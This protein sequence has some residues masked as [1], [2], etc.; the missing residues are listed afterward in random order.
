MASDSWAT[1]RKRVKFKGCYANGP[2]F[3]RLEPSNRRARVDP[4]TLRLDKALTR[5]F[6]LARKNK[7]RYFALQN[8]AQ[9]CLGAK[10]LSKKRRPNTDCKSDD[11]HG[12]KGG[13]PNTNSVFELLDADLTDASKFEYE[14]PLVGDMLECAPAEDGLFPLSLTQLFHQQYFTPSNPTKGQLIYQS[15]GSGKTCLGLNVIGNFMGKWRIFWVTRWSLRATPLKN[16]YQDICQMKLREII[17]SDQPLT[18]KSTGEVLGRTR[19]EKIAFIRSARGPAAL[20]SY[21]IQI[22]KQRILTYDDLIKM[23]L[24]KGAM[25]KKLREQQL[26]TNDLGDIGYK[27]LFVF[28]EAHNLFTSDLPSDERKE[29][30]RKISS[31]QFPGKT[32]RT[33]AEVYGQIPGLPDRL[34]GRDAL[35][36][37]LYESYRRSG[38]Q[39][40]KVLFLTATPMSDSPVQLFKMLN[41]LLPNPRQRLSL[42]LSDYYDPASL[43]LK[44]EQVVKFAKACYGRVSYLNITQD[45]TK[46]AKKV[47]GGVTKNQLEPFYERLVDKAVAKHKNNPVKAVETYRNM[48]LAARV[49]GPFF[50]AEVIRQHEQSYVDLMDSL[51]TKTEVWHE[52]YHSRVDEAKRVF[53]QT[54]K[55]SDEKAYQVRLDAY[56][57]WAQKASAKVPARVQEVLADDGRLLS[58]AEWFAVT[59]LP[60]RH[61]KSKK[62]YTKA[63]KLLLNFLIQDA[64]TGRYR[65]R[66]W[67]EYL[68]LKMEQGQEI[69]RLDRQ[70]ETRRGVSFLMWYKTYK[71]KVFVELMP[72]YAPKIHQCIENIVKFER[73]AREVYGHGFKHKVFT[74]SK[75]GKGVLGA[76]GARI[77]ASAFQARDEF[78]VCLVYKPNAEG[79]FVLHDNLPPR[80]KRWG[81]AVLSSKNM[82]NIYYRQHGGNKTVD[83]NAKVVAATQ[84]AFN[85]ARN[86]YGD[87]IKVIIM[88]KAFT[89]GV[90]AYDANIDHFLDRGTGRNPLE[91]AAARS[92]RLCRSKNL[93]FFRGVGSLLDMQFYSSQKASNPALDLY[94]DMLQHIPYEQQLAVNMIDAFEDLTR[95]F[96]LD[97]WLNYRLNN[98][99]PVFTGEI[100]DIYQNKDSY[101]IRQHLT[102]S[103]RTK[104]SFM[105]QSDKFRKKAVT[106]DFVV[107]RVSLVHPLRKNVAVQS[108]GV[109]GEIQS[110]SKTRDEYKVRVGDNVEVWPARE[111]FV[112]PGQQVK[113]HMPHGV[114]M[115]Q[116]FL[117]IG[118]YQVMH[119][120]RSEPITLEDVKVPS[121]ALEAVSTTFK[122]ETLHVLHG[123]VTLLRYVIAQGG[124]AGIPVHLVLPTPTREQALPPLGAWS[125]TWAEE[126]LFYRP[127]HWHQFVSASAGLSFMFLYVGDRANLLLY[128]PQWQTVERFDP[129]GVVPEITLDQ[130]LTDLCAKHGLTYMSAGQTS[131]VRGLERLQRAEKAQHDLDP[132]SFGQA[133]NL[134]YLQARVMH[135]KQSQGRNKTTYPLQFQRTLIRELGNKSLTQYIRDY[136]ELSMDAADF[137]TQWDG[138]RQNQPYWVNIILLIKDLLRLLRIK[139]KSRAWPKATRKRNELLKFLF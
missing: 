86:R 95:E 13:G 110:Y 24:N 104:D 135:A 117:N 28:D 44:D 88:D 67:S 129:L 19:A 128:V 25:G 4:T 63:E 80:G 69:P 43:A 38:R 115:A 102:W 113:F 36:A 68:S 124:T 54:V 98:F 118:N 35:A 116:R 46:F 132:V 50:S 108:H 106:K 111:L 130:A 74:F 123:L 126:E 120:G 21:G 42:R 83:Y 52:Y 91:Q 9:F 87:Y 7:Q 57:K 60:K 22:E 97:Y 79:K 89:E 14:S 138:Y 121:V 71:P 58:L 119:S 8:G 17:D 56:K 20:K 64:A 131:P 127:S 133:F 134:L 73:E 61:R 3:L 59:R 81:V 51:E 10:Q 37:M 92:T 112:I 96:S 33:P 1:I 66:T 109:L 47:F 125:L 5:C 40:C 45:P 31:I 65:V 101:V 103:N 49:K 30:D 16:L 62:N 93:P 137:V 55:A 99:A 18:L 122:P 2:E 12:F 84:A 53:G 29:L 114:S 32:F 41:L 27:T 82:P 26:A 136:A 75:A 100:V 139:H 34:T 94:S 78:Q 6:K 39:S 105:P 90:E 11:K 72:Y 70:P 77:I 48:G 85:D 15:A 23:I 107:D 76:Y